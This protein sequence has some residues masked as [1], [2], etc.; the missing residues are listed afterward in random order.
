M[1][2]KY[3]LLLIFFMVFALGPMQGQD[4]SRFA[5]HVKGPIPKIVPNTNRIL[6]T[7]DIYLN[8]IQADSLYF[9]HSYYM[10]YMFYINS[11]YTL[12][13]TGTPKSNEYLLQSFG[14]MFDTLIDANHKD[15]GYAS[16]IAENIIIDSLHITI[17]QSNHSGTQ[18]TIIVQIDSVAKDGYPTNTILHADT[19]LT[20]ITGLSASNDWLNPLNLT[21]KLKYPVALND[22]KFAVNV[23]YHGS[24]FDTMGFLPGFGD[25]TCH[26]DGSGVIPRQTHIGNYFGGLRANSFSSGYK[27]FFND[28]TRTIPDSNGNT[29]GVAISC[30]NPDLH[31]WYL[32]DNPISAYVTFTNV[33]GIKELSS[34][35]GF[36]V[37]Q[38]QPNPFNKNTLINYSLKSSANVAFGVYDLAGRCLLNSN[39]GTTASGM[40]SISLNADSFTPG[41]Y[42]YTF[43]INGSSVTRKMVITQ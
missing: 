40:H 13:D 39:Y 28:S 41:I 23:T 30:G 10:S 43:N 37:S 42:L 14:V 17:G 15:T 27:Y 4:I 22:N 6:N 9:P 7:S 25:T 8:Y 5:Y 18:D 29:F 26:F 11:A 1:K 31:Y 33:T 38:N 35:D 3:Y 12:S 34:L 2:G 36:N 32:Q 16:D 19:V 21:L 20:G 24:K